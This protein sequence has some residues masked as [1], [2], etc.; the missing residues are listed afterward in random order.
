M[1]TLK[2][3][4]EIKGMQAAGDIMVGLFHA[5]EDYIK[6]GITTWDVDHFAY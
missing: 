2:S 3:D 1:I 4:R 6:P 5:L